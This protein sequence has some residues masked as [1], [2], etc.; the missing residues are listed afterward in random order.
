MTQNGPK[1]PVNDPKWST[2]HFYD[3][4]SFWSKMTQMTQN[5]PKTPSLKISLKRGKILSFKLRIKIS[6]LNTD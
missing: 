1:R 3:F 5:N 2:T 4:Y 6:S